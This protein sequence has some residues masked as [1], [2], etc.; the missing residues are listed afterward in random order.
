MFQFFRTSL[1]VYSVL[2]P[3]LM[4]IKMYELLGSL[5]LELIVEML[6]NPYYRCQWNEVPLP[7]ANADVEI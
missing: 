5:K 2:T 7:P 1:W 3:S 4:Q 6:T